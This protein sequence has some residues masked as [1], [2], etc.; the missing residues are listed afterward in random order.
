MYTQTVVEQDT[1]PGM[2]TERPESPRGAKRRT[3]N[4][5]SLTTEFSYCDTCQSVANLGPA[6]CEDLPGVTDAYW[7]TGGPVGRDTAIRCAV[8]ESGH[9]WPV[10]YGIPLDGGRRRLVEGVGPVR[11]GEVSATAGASLDMQRV[12]VMVGRLVGR[13]VAR[14]WV[15][16]ATPEREYVHVGAR[17]PRTGRCTWLA[18]L[19][20]GSIFGPAGELRFG[21]G[22]WPCVD[23]SHPWQTAPVVREPLR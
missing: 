16:Y 22:D 5:W 17:N 21:G 19:T 14:G 1:L 3:T 20:E 9:A 10:S 4:R 15:V 12:R 8:S 13:A 2:A 6:P 18:V 23:L 11:P 7:V